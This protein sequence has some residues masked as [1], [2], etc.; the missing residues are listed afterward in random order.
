M[1]GS[2]KCVALRPLWLAGWLLV[3]LLPALLLTSLL[4]QGREAAPEHAVLV[5]ALATESARNAGWLGTALGVWLAIGLGGIPLLNRLGLHL[6]RGRRTG[7][8]YEQ[9]FRSV[10]DA[11]FLVEVEPGQEFRYLSSN[12]A[13]ARSTGIPTVELVGR[14]PGQ[15]LGPAAA[16][17]VVRQYAECVRR[18]A[19]Y[20]YEEQL[21]LPAGKKTW[22]TIL[23]PVLDERGE[24]RMLVGVGRDITGHTEEAIRLK[25]ITEHLPGF[26]YQ[27]RLDNR[28][29][30]S[31]TYASDSVARLFGVTPRAVID[32][33]ETLLGRIHRDDIDRVIAESMESARELISW[34][35]R[36]RMQHADG[37][38]LWV[39]AYDTP[40]VT[41]DGG[42]L[43]TGYAND[44]TEQVNLEEALRS[45]EARFRTLVE[46]ANDIIYTLD[47]DGSLTYVSPNWQ[48][49]LGHPPR[50]VTGR[51]MR[52]FVH[53]DD[54]DACQQ[55]LRA[56][57]TGGKKRGG[58]EYR[59][60]HINGDWHWHTS[61]GAPLMDEQ[62]TVISFLGIAR[63]IT[64]RKLADERIAHLAHYDALTDL[65][66]RS[67]FFEMLQRSLGRAR[68]E[69]RKLALLFVDLDRFKPVN[70]RYG[71][72][73]GDALL[74]AI[75]RRMNTCFRQSDLVAR[76][77]GD[78]F[79]V[80]L[81]GIE[82]LAD[83]E[84][85]A[86][87]LWTALAEPFEL[88]GLSLAVSSSIG[89]A[90]FPDHAGDGDELVQRADRAMYEAKALDRDAVCVWH[91]TAG[92]AS[93]RAR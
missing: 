55:F 67:L 88:D 59:V 8:V 30:W 33:A 46:N 45:S 21:D 61:N 57:V 5:S 47:R 66:N 48:D 92:E 43:W 32:D 20:T 65:P 63:D 64:E 7:A 37:H 31:Y 84:L 22:M 42:I 6:E 71:H 80:L 39:E 68:R 49:L 72:S 60:R 41:E 93:P 11:I 79:V 26:V 73:V 53:P 3:V 82:A 85:A 81:D 34:H 27:L 36:F 58:I 51:G 12:P 15:V 76:M 91:D 78:E 38:L 28:Q 18:K 90:V 54:L 77:G 4:V 25:S 86:R 50:E 23:N 13:H 70:D 1:S 16:A 17:H 62:G 19:A 56:V 89:I 35:S 87:K 2:R 9:V 83:A 75:A 40:V 69:H 44:I 29:R 74:Q 24:V 52:D 10:S 14:T